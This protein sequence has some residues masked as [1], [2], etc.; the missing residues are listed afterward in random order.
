MVQIIWSSLADDDMKMIYNYISLDSSF[1]AEKVLAKIFERTSI[2]ESQMH[3]GRIVPEFEN[4][5]IRELIEENYRIIYEIFEGS[6]VA[7]LRVFHRPM[8]LKEI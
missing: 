6:S 2:L 8:L 4:P 1:Y 3:I 7:I 5:S